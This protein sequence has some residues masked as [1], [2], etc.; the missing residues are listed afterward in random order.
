MWFRRNDPETWS[1][2]SKVVLPK[3]YIRLKLTGSVATDVTDAGGTL[4]LDVRA[5]AWSEDLFKIM[6][7]PMRI[8]PMV[9]EST[10][11]TGKVS[12]EAAEVTGIAHGTPV[13][14]GGADQIMAALGN[15]LVG[16]K[17]AVAIIGTGALVMTVVD[18]LSASPPIGLHFIPYVNRENW[19]VMGA[20]LNGGSCLDW[21]MKLV[22]NGA[23][24]SAFF[25]DIEGACEKVPPVPRGLIFLPYLHGERTPHMDPTAKGAF[26]GLDDG[27]GKYDVVKSVM[28]GVSFALRD[29]LESIKKTGVTV[30][31][32][33]AS[34]GGSKSPLWRQIQADVLNLPVLSMLTQEGSAYGAAMTVA[35]SLG[36]FESLEALCQK[37]IR[38]RER[39]LPRSD[40]AAVYKRYFSLYK[41][42]YTSLKGF[43][44][45]TVEIEHGRALNVG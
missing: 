33:K 39:I 1:R 28:E 32:I 14:G 44:R 35:L 34:G 7:I 24:K 31:S 13:C 2:V 26:V 25:E 30:D 43:Y 22:N 37:W 21:V 38:V 6:E 41:G 8:A 9:F 36:H 5:R 18:S 16:E 20:A 42:I 17:D 23:D 19:I 40:Q 11:I 10:E 12:K 27:H 29:C 15:G 3:D 45:D 4:L